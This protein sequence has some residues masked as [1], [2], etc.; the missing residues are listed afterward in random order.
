MSEKQLLAVR[1]RRELLDRIRTEASQQGRTIG[2]QIE[3][4]LERGLAAPVSKQ[5]AI[6]RHIRGDP[7]LTTVAELAE[8]AGVTEDVILQRIA[9]VLT[10]REAAPPKEK[11]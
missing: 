11:R 1:L 8:T 7:Q 2:G 5:D 4:L 3:I 10:K 9:S 6:V